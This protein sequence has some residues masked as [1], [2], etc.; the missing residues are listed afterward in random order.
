MDEALALP[1]QEAAQVALRTQQIIG[2]ESGVTETVDP[3]AGSYF[4]EQLTDTLETRAK[5]Y[6]DKIDELG[7]ALAA[8]EQGYIQR[9]I[10]EAAYQYQREIETQERIIVG[11]NKF[12]VEEDIVPQLLRV[13]ESVAY[14]Q[15]E[16]LAALRSRREGAAT[17]QTLEGLK[18][19]AQGSDNLMPY[20]LSAVEAYA[21]TGEICHTLRRVWGEYR[22]P[23]IL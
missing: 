1:T 17:H 7:G 13:D 11:L 14:K 20:I 5:A 10:Q 15:R 23:A 3:L 8:I 4:V 9:E 6:I 2:Y 19:A 16:R 18:R 22:P 12:T 21:T